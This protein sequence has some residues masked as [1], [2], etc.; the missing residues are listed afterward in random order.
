MPCL[1]LRTS[2]ERPITVSLGTN[3]IV[4]DDLTRAYRACDEVL[5][6]R[7]QR[8]QAIRGWDGRA[9]ERIAA[10]LTDAWAN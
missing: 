3:T 8:G 10:V 5:A 2:T 7:Y 9:S 4:G 1:T 6:G